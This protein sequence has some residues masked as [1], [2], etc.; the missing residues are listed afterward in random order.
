MIIF[1]S[2]L[3]RLPIWDFYAKRFGFKQI[4][5]F[6]EELKKFTMN[7]LII[8]PKILFANLEDFMMMRQI[9]M[10][11]TEITDEVNTIMKVNS[12]DIKLAKSLSTGLD[13]SKFLPKEE[14]LNRSFSF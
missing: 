12:Q 13:Y 9:L 11:I 5:N 10:R 6:D 7:F 14:R 1:W 3:M 2:W 8:D 4:T